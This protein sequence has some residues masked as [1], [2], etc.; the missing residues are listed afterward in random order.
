MKRLAV[1]LLVMFVSLLSYGQ[2]HIGPQ[3][4]YTSSN[5]TINVDSISAG[6]RSN[7]LAGVFM[8]FGNKLYVAP[9]VNWLT[10]G[11]VFKVPSYSTGVS[12]LQQEIKFNSLQVPLNL[13][14]RLIDLKVVNVRIFGGVAANFIL[15]TTVTT[16][17]GN[18][19]DYENALVP[20]DFKSAIWQWDVGVGVDVL[21][22]AVDFKYLGGINNIMDD[23]QYNN[24][25]ISSKS[26]LFV[27]TLGWKIL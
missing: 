6:M 10:Q 20:S 7:F 15:N 19:D 26:N 25:T 2:F 16:T 22:F 3:V 4:G 24:T 18:A 13:G 14:L 5:L 23:V 12:P 8:R 17:E 1:L 11:S 9:E 27:V 21:M